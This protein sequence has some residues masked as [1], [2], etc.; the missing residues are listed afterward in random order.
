MV[1]WSEVFR[2]NKQHKGYFLKSSLSEDLSAIA[3]K[4]KLHNGMSASVD[5]H[6][7]LIP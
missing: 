4:K 3:E 7:I 2:W 1:F 5:K 6:A